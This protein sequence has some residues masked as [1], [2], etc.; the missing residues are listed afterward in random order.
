MGLVSHRGLLLIPPSHRQRSPSES[1]GV[2]NVVT[3]LGRG[4]VLVTVQSIVL[5][6]QDDKQSINICYKSMNTGF[7]T[8]RIV[9]AVLSHT[10]LPA[11][12]DKETVYKGLEQVQSTLC[13]SS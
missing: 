8:E 13:F 12:R 9:R 10:I 11:E 1:I 7:L 2:R 4:E 5:Y 6:S 3:T